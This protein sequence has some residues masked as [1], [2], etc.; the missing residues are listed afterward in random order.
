MKPSMPKTER[1]QEDD[2]SKFRAEQN[3]MH[4]N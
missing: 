2:L 1:Y 4:G 3:D